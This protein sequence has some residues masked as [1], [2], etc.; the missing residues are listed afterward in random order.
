MTVGGNV[1]EKR[2]A[3]K[4]LASLSKGWGRSAL[5]HLGGALVSSLEKARGVAAQASMRPF[6]CNRFN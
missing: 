3:Y 6:Y 1:K 5:M 4:F 2:N